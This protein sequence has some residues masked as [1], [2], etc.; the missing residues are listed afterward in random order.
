MAEK[1]DKTKLARE[2]LFE[3]NLVKTSLRT[4]AHHH[5]ESF[6]YGLGTCLP[7]IN[8]YMHTA[9]INHP[10]AETE[11]ASLPFKKL[12]LWFESIDLLKPQRAKDT[13]S[14]MLI[15]SDDRGKM[16]P[17]ECRLRGLTYAAPL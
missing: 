14:S 15:D 10:D 2:A 11:A 1:L 3:S 9:E 4:V 8:Q 13:S 17:S 5:V 7:R 16:F 6:N 12:Q